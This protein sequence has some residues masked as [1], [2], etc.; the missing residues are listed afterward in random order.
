MIARLVRNDEATRL[1]PLLVPLMIAFGAIAALLYGENS[2]HRIVSST[3]AETDDRIVFTNQ[4]A[5]TLG[6]IF[7]STCRVHLRSIPFHLGLPI[8]ARDLWTARMIALTMAT[9]LP[10]GVGFATYFAVN[11][12]ALG[13]PAVNLGLDILAVL[14]VAPILFHARFTKANRA[15]DV[16]PVRHWILFAVLFLGM[17]MVVAWLLPPFWLVGS[18]ALVVVAALATLTRSMLPAT[19]ELSGTRSQRL[20]PR[21]GVSFRLPGFLEWSLISPFAPLHRAMRLN[22]LVSLNLVA[23]SLS[24]LAFVSI[25]IPRGKYIELF[26]LA[27]FQVLLFAMSLVGLPM[28]AHLPFSKTRLFAKCWLPGLGVALLALVVGLRG[29]PNFSFAAVAA[30]PAAAAG[31][32]VYWIV[33]FLGCSALLL[34][35][36]GPAPTK[37]GRITRTLGRLLYALAAVGAL[38]FAIA[39]GFGG[40][41]PA[42]RNPAEFYRTLGGGIP[43][44]A[45]IAWILAFLIAGGSIVALRALFGRIEMTW[46]TSRMHKWLEKFA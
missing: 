30:S 3:L 22:L 31:F 8:A 20:A 19:F 42:E 24:S 6:G 23:F 34:P 28:V 41:D 13:S 12:N 35:L 45:A 14:F 32:A 2:T 29:D 27:I 25:A 44:P 26:M 11:G 36:T 39:P 37:R 16:R 1:L 4:I 5:L 15:D 9:V 7:F 40:M 21:R 33:V 43:G 10:A 17:E 46:L 18:M 38:G